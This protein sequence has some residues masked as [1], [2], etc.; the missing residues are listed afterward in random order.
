MFAW[1]S[2]YGGANKLTMQG[3]AV[4]GNSAVQGGGIFNSGDLTGTG[5]MLLGN[6]QPPVVGLTTPPTVLRRSPVGDHRQVAFGRR[7][8]ALQR[9]DR[10][11]GVLRCLGQLGGA[12]G[13]IYA[14]AGGR[15]TLTGTLVI[16]NKKDNIA[17]IVTL[18]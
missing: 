18:T 8:R 6:S 13:G 14:A 15:V 17:G 2:P 1:S 9:W 3:V 12:G 10:R 11:A 7:R 16:G 5:I 4:I